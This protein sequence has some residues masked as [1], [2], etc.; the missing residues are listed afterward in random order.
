M[1]DFTARLEQEHDRLASR[2]GGVISRV[3][4][5]ALFPALRDLRVCA[6]EL[7]EHVQ[8]LEQLLRMNRERLLSREEEADWQAGT[9]ALERA[10]VIAYAMLKTEN[11]LDALE[12]LDEVLVRFREQVAREYRIFARL[13]VT[14]A[15]PPAWAALANALERVH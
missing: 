3:L 11:R 7:G 12:A 15:P 10:V 5:D 8:T 4:G 13:T 2:L 1:R 14:E 6:I 9:A